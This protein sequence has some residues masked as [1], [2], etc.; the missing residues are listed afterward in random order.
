MKNKIK[1]FLFRRKTELLKQSQD[2]RRKKSLDPKELLARID[3]IDELWNVIDE[4]MPSPTASPTASPTKYPVGIDMGRM[5]RDEADGN[6]YKKQEL[7][8]DPFLDDDVPG[9]AVP[10][11]FIQQE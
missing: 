11:D 6:L 1:E 4:L 10:V 2:G 8:G 5:D 7:F 9:K 3:E